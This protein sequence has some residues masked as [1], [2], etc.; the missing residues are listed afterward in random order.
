MSSAFSRCFLTSY[1]CIPVPYNEK[2]IF[3]GCYFQKVLSVFVELFNFSFF[4]ISGWSIELDYCDR[5][6][7]FKL[8]ELLSVF[9]FLLIRNQHVMSL[10][11]IRHCT[12]S[13]IYIIQFN[14]R[15]LPREHTGHSKH[16]LPTTQETALH[17]DITR[18]S[19]PKSD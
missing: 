10:L 4:S 9:I 15:V 2:D 17:M 5:V 19:T 14:H 6:I 3:F 1:F 16:P 11:Y 8:N 13:F 12:N 7:S 18:W